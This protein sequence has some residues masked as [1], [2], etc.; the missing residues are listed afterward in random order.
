MPD[1]RY[2]D[3]ARLLCLHE[4]SVAVVDEDGHVRSTEVSL[5]KG[6]QPFNL[7]DGDT[8]AP[9]IAAGALHVQKLDVSAF[10]CQLRLYACQIELRSHCCSPC[11]RC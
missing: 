3:V 8:R 6:A 7:S 4:L 5:D 10:V 2:P 9:L 11:C 1:G